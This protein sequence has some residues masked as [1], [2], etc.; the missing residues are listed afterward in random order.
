MGN[1]T[2]RTPP[3][4]RPTSALPVHAYVPGRDPHA[5]R[6]ARGHGPVVAAF[7]SEDQWSRN[8]DFLW[9]VDLYNGGFFWEA[10]EAWEEL[11]RAAPLDSLQRSFLQGLI[12]CAAASLKAALGDTTAC[13]RL[14]A[15]ALR[16]LERVRAGHPDRYMG[17][18]LEPFIADFRAFVAATAAGDGRGPFI[19]LDPWP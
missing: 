17:L 14:S 1:T 11:W 2:S 5:A 12:Q 9:G 8:A 16:R 6:P 18:A 4:Y 7:L 10:H 3:R 15:R 13:M 19:E